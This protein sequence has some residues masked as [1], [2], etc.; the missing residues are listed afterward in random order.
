MP[1][2]QGT[3]V[4]VKH[5]PLR[6]AGVVVTMIRAGSPKVA[7]VGLN[8]SNTA[9]RLRCR[10]CPQRGLIR[11][12]STLTQYAAPG[13]CGCGQGHDDRAVDNSMVSRYSNWINS[14]T[15]A[16]AAAA[17]QFA[18]VQAGAILAHATIRICRS[19]PCRS[20]SPKAGTIPS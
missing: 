6:A 12:R 20:M 13:P 8:A 14:P 5:Q 11:R 4:E 19:S 17:A 16:Y 9:S 3:I 15:P 18:D 10:Q 7:I 2:G 1:I